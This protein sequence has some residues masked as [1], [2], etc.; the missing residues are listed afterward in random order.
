M[1]AQSRDY[2]EVLGV[3]KSASGE[4][5]KRAYR[6][7]AKKFHPDVNKEADAVDKFKELQ[8]AY[9]VLSDDGKRKQYDRFGEAGING[10]A[11]GFSGGFG[12]ADDLFGDLFATIFQDASGGGRR[13]SSTVIQGDDLAV[14]LEITLEDAVLG[15][16]KVI[17]YPRL[18][19]SA[20]Q[21]ARSPS[22]ILPTSSLPI[23]A[24]TDR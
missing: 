10:A 21:R 19:P 22:P 12:S 6:N 14:E 3:S 17:R 20:S 24:K 18:E 23:S 8:T 9:G 16:E 13:Q 4:E 15:A 5:I 1:A 2:Y 7:L 11:G